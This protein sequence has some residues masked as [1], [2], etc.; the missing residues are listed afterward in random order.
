MH[1]GVKTVVTGPGILGCPHE[2][3]SIIRKA[4]FV[5][6]ALTGPAA[7]DQFE[8]HLNSVQFRPRGFSDAPRPDLLPRNPG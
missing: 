3:E 8:F 4:A 6:A 5:R 1:G 7:S 2:E